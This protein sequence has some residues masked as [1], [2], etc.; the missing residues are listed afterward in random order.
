MSLCLSNL[1][2]GESTIRYGNALERAL[3]HPYSVVK[4]MALKEIKRSLLNEEVIYNI[5][6]KTELIMNIIACLKD[7]D[8]AVAKD[9]SD[10]MFTLG[11]TIPGINKITSSDI[12]A[13]LES[14][15]QTNELTRLRIF[16]VFN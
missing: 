14:T 12:L 3:I 2:L 5:C 6:T 1:T 10:I 13:C 11:I 8:L 9:A 7:D 16:E 4:L 15:M